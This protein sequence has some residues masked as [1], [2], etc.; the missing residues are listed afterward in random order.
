[1]SF[2]LWACF[3]KGLRPGDEILVLNGSDVSTLDLGLLQTH[4]CQLKLSLV[5][6][7]EDVCLEAQTPIW[8]DA[9]PT[10]F[11]LPV[12]PPCHLGVYAGMQDEQLSARI[13]AGEVAPSAVWPMLLC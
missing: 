12:P 3:Y 7:R 1:M 4:F 13:S 8:P 9:R 2:A 5:L 6:R 10:D 11:S